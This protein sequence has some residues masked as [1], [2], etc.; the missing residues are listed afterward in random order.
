MP[1]KISNPDFNNAFIRPIEKRD[2]HQV[3]DL[4]VSVMSDYQCV[5]EGYSSSDPEVTTMFDA[6]NIPRARFYVIEYQGTIFGCG[7]LAPL[8]D[9][10]A[11]ICEL[12]KMYFY[13]ELRGCGFG[14]R[15]L[16]MCIDDAR[17]LGFKKMYL[18]TVERMDRAKKLY[19]GFG[20]QAIDHA[21][22]HTGHS[23]CDNFY[24]KDI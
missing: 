3:A 2:E 8:Q 10:D 12:R 11:S 6:Y 16:Q 22:G 4:I 20:F 18:E 21:M 14:R 7:G 15:L 1:D 13:N 24:I 19:L 23:G 5:G 9:G 17:E